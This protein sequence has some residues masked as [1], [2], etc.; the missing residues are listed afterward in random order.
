[1]DTGDKVVLVTQREFYGALT[2]VWTFIMLAFAQSVF[3]A[4][5]S[6]VQANVIYLAISFLMVITSAAASW[7]GN[8]SRRT[9]TV[10]ILLAVVALGV[11]AG[12]YFAGASAK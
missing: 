9:A 6:P 2:L 11:G 4:P 5:R 3:N 1:M 8:M 12:A 10:A 7:R